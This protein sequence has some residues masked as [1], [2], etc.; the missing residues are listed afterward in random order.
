MNEEFVED[1][2]FRQRYRFG[3]DGDVLRVEIRTDPGGGVLADH[4][5]PQLEERYQVLKGEVTF[6]VDGKPV[7]AGPGAKVVVTPGVRH[8]FQNTGTETS[9]LDVEAEPALQL[10]ESI[11]EGASLARTE[12]FSA[13]AKPRSFRALVAAA[14][15]ADRYRETVVLSSP[16][17]AVQRLLF[18]LL[19][20]FASS[21]R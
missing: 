3:R 19:A 18:P 10:R 2:L 12:K 6:R 15:L 16:P 13:T 14:A 7:V 5:H 21:A 11:E 1:P 17:P 20:R 4:V 9:H 8:S